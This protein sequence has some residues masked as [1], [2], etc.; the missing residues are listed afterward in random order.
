MLT[1]RYNIVEMR[2]ENSWDAE[3]L[4]ETKNIN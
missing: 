2:F 4:I 1:K 3:Y